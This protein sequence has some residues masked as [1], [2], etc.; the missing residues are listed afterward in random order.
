MLSLVHLNLKVGSP[1]DEITLVIDQY[2][3]QLESEQD[4]ADKLNATTQADCDDQIATFNKNI[5]DFK[6]QIESLNIQ[7]TEN[8]AILET[9][10]KELAQAQYDFQETVKQIEAGT[11]QREQEHNEWAQKDYELSIDITTVEEG[12]RLVQ[13]MLHGVSFAQVETKYNKIVEK[14]QT[15]GTRQI[16]F[17]PLVSQLVQITSK[18]NYE[19]VVKVLELLNNIR[20]GLVNEQTE[21]RLQEEQAQKDWE[22]LLATLT[23]HK[24]ALSDKIAQKQAAI[25]SLTAVLKTDKKSLEDTTFN[26]SNEEENLADKTEACNAASVKYLTETGEREK[27]LE[28]LARLQTYITEKLRPV[29]DYLDTRSYWSAWIIWFIKLHI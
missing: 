9:N 14:L 12:I 17:K 28:I 13:H 5:G 7:I 29:Q 1:V 23:A 15:K 2:T 26:L 27:Q 25:A 3:S 21:A 6:R 8:T 22:K 4:D 11:A 16:L 10:K 20:V 24:Q 18:F 19:N